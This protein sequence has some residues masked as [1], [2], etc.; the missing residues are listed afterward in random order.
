MD[1]V[2]Q[3]RLKN[4]QTLPSLPGVAFHILPLCAGE[5]PDLIG[6]TKVISQ[7]PALTLPVL[8]L[9]NSH[10]STDFGARFTP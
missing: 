2:V 6:M 8:R 9:V 4:C 3:E 5:H 10:L 1:L 7:N